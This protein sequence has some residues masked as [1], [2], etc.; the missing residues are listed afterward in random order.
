MSAQ[1]C[2]GSVRKVTGKNQGGVMVCDP[3]VYLWI[4][5]RKR[6]EQN[7]KYCDEKFNH[8][9]ESL[10]KAELSQTDTNYLAS[11]YRNS[12][13]TMSK[14]GQNLSVCVKFQQT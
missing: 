3:Y 7:V 10:Y 8:S 1:S 6:I 2:N 9:L 12:D 13:T 14:N 5:S 11:F 4:S